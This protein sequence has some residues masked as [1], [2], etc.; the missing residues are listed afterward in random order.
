MKRPTNP[1]TGHE[2]GSDE[3]LLASCDNLIR[4]IEENWLP[5]INERRSDPNIRTADLMR[6]S[7]ALSLVPLAKAR[8]TDAVLTAKLD[9][10][11]DAV[12][13]YQDALL[14]EPAKAQA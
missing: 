2:V 4:E 3:S 12:K 5:N 14:V 11:S 13:R 7:L 9:Q 10:T 8:C 1:Y 6:C